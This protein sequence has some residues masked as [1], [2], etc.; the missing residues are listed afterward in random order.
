MS[1]AEEILIEE[2]KEYEN[3]LNE[4]FCSPILTETM[5][6]HI[7]IYRGIITA[8]EKAIKRIQEE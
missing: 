6:K 7:P 4:I 8:L 1:S 3:K 2:K 5:D